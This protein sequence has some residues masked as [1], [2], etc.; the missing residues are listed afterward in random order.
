MRIKKGDLVACYITNTNEW[1][2]LVGWGIVLDVNTSLEDILVLDNA[3]NSRWWP[4]K[5][6]KLLAKKKQIK[7]LDIDVKL[8]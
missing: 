4:D 8:A 1:R 5:R 6:W 2:A 3:G 7:H